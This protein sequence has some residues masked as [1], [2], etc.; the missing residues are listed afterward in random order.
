[1]SHEHDKYEWVEISDIE[2]Y[3]T[4]GEVKAPE[5]LDLN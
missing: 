1:M 5:R 3:D 4:L 2:E